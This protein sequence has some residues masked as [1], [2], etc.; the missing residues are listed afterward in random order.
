MWKFF[1]KTPLVIAAAAL[2]VAGQPFLSHVYETTVRVVKRDINRL[3][4]RPDPELEFASGTRVSKK[5]EIETARTVEQFIIEASR[6]WRLDPALIRAVIKTES[7]FDPKAVSPAGAMGLMQLM[8]ETAFDLGV[9][10]PFDPKSNIYGGVKLLRVLIDTY[11]S[12]DDAL[13]GY[14]AGPRWVGRKRLPNETRR[15][16]RAVFYF[17]TKYREELESGDPTGEMADQD[18]PGKPAKLDEEKV[19]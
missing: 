4:N 14:N 5:I 17:Y 2:L 16:I 1:I 18:R 9:T 12:V 7:N 8:P 3:L 10:D 6:R 13:V 11:G 19:S 15:Y